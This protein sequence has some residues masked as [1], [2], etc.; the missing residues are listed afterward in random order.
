MDNSLLRACNEL[1]FITPRNSDQIP[2][3]T[4]LSNEIQ[5][6]FLLA[7][8]ELLQ[9]ITEEDRSHRK[10]NNSIFECPIL[11]YIWIING[12]TKRGR[13]FTPKLSVVTDNDAR[14]LNC[15]GR[16]IALGSYL[17]KMKCDL[18][19][20]TMPDHAAI[21]LELNEVLYFCDI[22][23][24][25]L[26]RLH[27]SITTHDGYRWYKKD[28]RDTFFFNYI[29]IH[30]FNSGI[31][32]AIMES[33]VF[34]QNPPNRDTTEGEQESLVFN[35]PKFQLSNS[36]NCIDWKKVQKN[37]FGSM[38]QYRIQYRKEYLLECEHVENQRYLHSLRV[39][40]DA[41]V[42]SIYESTLELP[43]EQEGHKAFI[44][45]NMH[46]LQEY[47]GE[48]DNFLRGVVPSIDERIPSKL[49]KYFSDMRTHIEVDSELK[50]Y[51]LFRLNNRINNPNLVA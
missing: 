29:I 3:L 1:V 7:A 6:D 32:N 49:Q 51:T 40:F 48:I 50:S 25:E 24:I 44:G 35:H 33:F 28:A 36:L 15:L 39:K 38:N 11:S 8:N 9:T 4:S 18:Y 42:R 14:G 47:Y 27:G 43:Y 16:T 13:G 19:L 21:I 30:D 31:I 23:N 22:A 17:R 20:G 37:Y 34:L 46:L 41:M 10:V 45:V 5:K 2:D 12:F 26:K